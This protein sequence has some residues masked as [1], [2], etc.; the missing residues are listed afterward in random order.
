MS[1]DP[2]FPT[3]STQRPTPDRFRFWSREKLR[4]ADT[5]QFRHVNNAS[6]ASFL[7]GG[8]MELFAAPAISRLMNG[9]NVV[10]GRLNIEFHA[11]IF[12][13][14]QLDIGSTVTHIGRSSFEVLQ[15]IFRDGTCVASAVASC[16]LLKAGK[17][18]AIPNDIRR[19]LLG[20]LGDSSNSAGA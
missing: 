2:A 18:H 8:R 12:Y 4:N 5:D 7:E 1:R 15:A 9:L 3:P 17:P 16:V 20:D 13:P 11:E 10:V 19:H 14:G 6:I